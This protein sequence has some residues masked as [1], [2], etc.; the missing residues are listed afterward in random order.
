MNEQNNSNVYIKVWILSAMK[1]PYLL[2]SAK[3]QG[4]R[5]ASVLFLYSRDLQHSSQNCGCMLYLVAL[6]SNV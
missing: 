6:H 1:K 3:M 5:M 4:A 2:H